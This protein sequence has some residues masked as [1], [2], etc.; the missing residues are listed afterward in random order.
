M[1]ISWSIST[2]AY[3]QKTWN[4]LGSLG[5]GFAYNLPASRYRFGPYVL[6]TLPTIRDQIASPSR[7]LLEYSERTDHRC[8]RSTDL[9]GNPNLALWGWSWINGF[10]IDPMFGYNT[11]II[12]QL[13]FSVDLDCLNDALGYFIQ[14]Q[15]FL[16]IGFLLPSDLKSSLSTELG[17]SFAGFSN[18]GVV[19]D[20]TTDYRLIP[21]CHTVQY[22]G[23]IRP[24]TDP[25]CCFNGM[26]F[27]RPTGGAW[28]GI[29]D[30]YQV[31]DA[32]AGKLATNRFPISKPTGTF[33]LYDVMNTGSF[34]S[35]TV[36]I[37]Y[38]DAFGAV[39]ST[40]TAAGSPSMSDPYWPVTLTWT[41]PTGAAYAE[42]SAIWY[43]SS[44]G[45]ISGSASASSSMAKL[46]PMSTQIGDYLPAQVRVQA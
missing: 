19:I 7:T 41:L 23:G 6:G 1:T 17:L 9:T 32:G 31:I 36:D 42:G 40:S 2:D 34:D 11:P 14:S 33:F 5:A 10:Y 15:V 20:D 28:P 29:N 39:V 44:S 4:V 21:N 35:V 3:G 45:L 8:I 12:N 46:S 27:R 24:T 38:R 43:D 37:V 18:V 26:S 30:I 13:I 25:W 16:G 22:L